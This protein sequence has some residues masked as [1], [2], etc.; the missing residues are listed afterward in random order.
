M[1]TGDMGDTAHRTFLGFHLYEQ[2]A[3]STNL[4]MNSSS[5]DDYDA[6]R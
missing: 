3:S 1:M 2:R 4:Q 6:H 5:Y